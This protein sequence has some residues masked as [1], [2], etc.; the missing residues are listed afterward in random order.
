MKRIALIGMPNTGKS[1]LFNRLTGAHAKVG[2]WQASPSSCSRPVLI[3]GTWSIGGPAWDLRP[4]HIPAAGRRHDLP[5]A[6]G[7]SGIVV[8][9]VGRA[10]I[11][12]WARSR[13]LAC[14]ILVLNMA[15]KPRRWASPSAAKH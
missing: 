2:N 5:G 1:T 13:V 3:G 6:G 8:L 15:D 4:A 7:R 12:L 14:L 9:N 11:M 10:Q